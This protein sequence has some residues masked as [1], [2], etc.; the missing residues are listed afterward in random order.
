MQGHPRSSKNGEGYFDFC[1]KNLEISKSKALANS[2]FC[3]NKQYTKRNLI[4]IHD[5]FGGKKK[6]AKIRKK[7]SENFT[8]K[9]KVYLFI[10]NYLSFYSWQ[11]R[12][13]ST[14]SEDGKNVHAALWCPIIGVS[15]EIVQCSGFSYLAGESTVYDMG[16]SDVFRSYSSFY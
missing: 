9:V 3:E 5:L 15:T 14:Q 13:Q 2:T 12:H 6:P 10:E 11:S 7:K 1:K 4:V 8:K 16:P